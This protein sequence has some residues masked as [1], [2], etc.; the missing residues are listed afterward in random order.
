LG[1]SNIIQKRTFEYFSDTST[2]TKNHIVSMLTDIES[3]AYIISCSYNVQSY[4]LETHPAKKFKLLDS[5]IDNLNYT[6]ASNNGIKSIRILGKDGQIIKSGFEDTFTIFQQIQNDYDIQT[7]KIKNA[8]YT[9][10]YKLESSQNK[11][12]AYVYPIYSVIE[13][14]SNNENIGFCIIVYDMHVL[15][16]CISNTS[17]MNLIISNNGEIITSNTPKYND[18]VNNIVKKISYK[19]TDKKIRING[20]K[21]IIKKTVIKNTGWEIINFAS[22]RDCIKDFIPIRNIGIIIFVT[23]AIILAIVGIIIM[24]SITT[25][26]SEIVYSMNSLG[27][28]KRYTKDRLNVPSSNE[29]GIIAMDINNM[30][31]RLENMSSKI[32]TAQDK[33]YQ[34]EIEKNKAE[35]LFYQSQI[36]PHF[37]YNTLECIRSIGLF[38]KAQEIVDISTSMGDMFRYCV[39]E[40]NTVTLHKELD[41]V[42]NYFNIMSIRYN[43]RFTLNTVIDK[44]ILNTSIVRMILQPIVENAIKHGLC[45]KKG[46]I[47]I[48]GCL[49][50]N[51]DVLIIISDNGVGMSKSKVCDLNKHIA[52]RNSFD[53]NESAIGLQNI[54]IR[55]KLTYGEKYGIKISSLQN[56]GT[57]VRVLIPY[58][59]MS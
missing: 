33:A 55:L 19:E 46:R 28:G 27:H 47:N 1:Y 12:F 34:A 7:N 36:N 2:Q 6:L 51:D 26:L 42:K 8:F 21:Y 13:G 40:Q 11:Y 39:Q 58:N 37:L 29:V 56:I 31:D 54:N 17:Y 18:N 30:L 24:K 38:Y 16:S 50:T 3:L 59:I 45:A 14:Y 9:H 22:I 49:N 10:P 41:C 53:T 23:T 44:D 32:F 20:K 5:A 35:L 25:P 43:N 48:K 57:V 52:N 15:T 4:L